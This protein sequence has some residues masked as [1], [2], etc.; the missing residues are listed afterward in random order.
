MSTCMFLGHCNSAR[1]IVGM[2]KLVGFFSGVLFSQPHLPE[3]E[4]FD[5][6]GQLFCYLESDR[7]HRSE[8]L[9]AGRTR[10]A[11]SICL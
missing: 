2:S 9:F 4:I 1:W 3:V 5:L 11:G 8:L 10:G 7:V 6:F